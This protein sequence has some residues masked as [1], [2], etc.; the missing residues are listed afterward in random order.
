MGH[1]KAVHLKSLKKYI[2]AQGGDAAW[3]QLLARLSAEDRAAASKPVLVHEWIEYAFWWRLLKATDQV[4]GTGDLAVVRAIGAF[5][6]QENLSTI[7]KVFLTML[8][9]EFMLARSQFIWRQYYDSGVLTVAQGGPNRAEVHLKD[10]PGLPVG[11]EAEIIGWMGAA[12]T[13]AGMK[14][15]Q[16]THPGPC[17]ARGDDHCQFIVTWE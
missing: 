14:G 16:V 12:I 6:A 7:Y 2:V 5:D 1:T 17:L 10:F 9:P 4:L 8:K 11:H 15:C 13:M 3:E